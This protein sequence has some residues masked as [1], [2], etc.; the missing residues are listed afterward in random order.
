MFNLSAVAV[1]LFDLHLES[2]VLKALNGYGQKLLECEEI[3]L[4]AVLPEKQC[5]EWLSL[6]KRICGQELTLSI[7]QDILWGNTD[8]VSKTNDHNLYENGS[9]EVSFSGLNDAQHVMV[10]IVDHSSYV[11]KANHI[12]RSF[13][14]LKDLLDLTTTLFFVLDKEFNVVFSNQAF[15]EHS[16]GQA[17]TADSH[18]KQTFNQSIRLTRSQFPQIHENFYDSVLL[19]FSSKENHQ[20]QIEWAS[21]SGERHIFHLLFQPLVHQGN[22]VELLLILGSD[23]TELISIYE[24]Q[25]RLHHALIE[26]QRLEAV[27]QM[28]GTIAHDFNGFLT[29][30]F[31][32]LSLFEPNDLDEE[33][34]ELIDGMQRVCDQ[35]RQLTQK[36]LAFSRS[37]KLEQNLD[38]SVSSVD[39]ID[40]HFHFAIHRLGKALAKVSY[41]ANLKQMS[42]DT[43]KQYISMS[44]AQCSQLVINLVNNAVEAIPENQLGVVKVTL[45]ST[46]QQLTIKVS[47]NGIGISPQQQSIIFEPFFTTKREKG[48]TGLGLASAKSLAVQ[49]G[50][51]LSLISALGKG[52][53][54][55]ITLPL[56]EGHD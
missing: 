11:Q 45:E 54:F 27:G 8:E 48:G 52:S 39:K 49:A 23:I 3:S 51:D 40:E 41:E 50:G 43:H 46:E 34:Q 6:A 29:I 20:G 24:E 13:Q 44:E 18:A 36:L 37:Q 26:A 56:T 15:L 17:K 16:F 1:P 42:H 35:A 4:S 19:C 31:S 21:K 7:K 28:A 32:S 9:F 2:Q 47:D 10:T 38:T 53:T 12:Q 5:Q 22:N 25:E 30:L 14:F 33:Q 55:V